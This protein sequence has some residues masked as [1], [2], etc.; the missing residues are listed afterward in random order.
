MRKTKRLVDFGKNYFSEKEGD[1][2]PDRN[3]LRDLSL[4]VHQSLVDPLP[5]KGGVSPMGAIAKLRIDRPPDRV[6]VE[7]RVELADV[8]LE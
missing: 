5:K 7:R 4:K 8:D 6:R 1:V 2:V 3:A